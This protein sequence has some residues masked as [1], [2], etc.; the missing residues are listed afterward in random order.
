MEK[1]KIRIMYWKEIPLQVECTQGENR[2]SSQLE[3]RFQEAADSIAMF[4]GSYGSDDYLDGFQWVDR[5]KKNGN[6]EEVLKELLLKINN[7]MPKNFVSRIRD[8]IKRKKR[9]PLPGA[10]D[11]WWS[12]NE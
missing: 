1:A 5:G 3:S 7:G 6:S 2:A 11:H 8:L 9:Q 4:D 12:G 10:I